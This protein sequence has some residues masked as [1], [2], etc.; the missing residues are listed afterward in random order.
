MGLFDDLASGK[1]TALD[2][3]GLDDGEAADPAAEA[4]EDTQAPV[5]QGAENH[6]NW[7]TPILV[8]PG[9][10]MST[11]L[12]E[13]QA[14]SIAPPVASEQTANDED[15]A[16]RQERAKQLGLGRLPI[17]ATHDDAAESGAIGPTAANA[18]APQ[19]V[20]KLPDFLKSMFRRPDYPAKG[21]T[22]W[23][24]TPTD[25]QAAFVE[26]DS[27]LHFENSKDPNALRAGLMLARERGWLPATLSGTP[28]FCRKAFLEACQLGIPTTGYKPTQEDLAHLKTLGAV[29]PA[30]SAAAAPAPGS[31]APAVAL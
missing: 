6:G 3:G 31:K 15:A 13:E 21:H 18:P 2:I 23:Y 1:T 12:S 16:K 25:K 14:G 30:L 9:A 28:G 22:S 11:G 20:D 10:G 8:P 7:N 5:L 24:L 4:V 17:D 29:I 26:R 19:G 27:A